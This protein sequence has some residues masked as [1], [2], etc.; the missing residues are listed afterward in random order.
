MR[1]CSRVTRAATSPNLT[2]VARRP[3]LIQRAAELAAIDVE[4]RQAVTGE[5]RIVLITGD[6]GLG[7]TRLVEL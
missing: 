3:Q 5:M 1:W 2:Q 7:K 6:Q 4:R